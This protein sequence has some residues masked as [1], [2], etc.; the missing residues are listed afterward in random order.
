[1]VMSQPLLVSKAMTFAQVALVISLFLPSEMAFLVTTAMLYPWFSLPVFPTAKV[2]LHSVVSEEMTTMMP[3]LVSQLTPLHFVSLIIV[4]V[5]A[6]LLPST[7]ILLVVLVV[8]LAMH[9]GASE[10]LLHL[11]G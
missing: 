10:Q 6:M 5:K 9:C 1:M 8:Y 3:S 4:V 7:L 11:I 2:F